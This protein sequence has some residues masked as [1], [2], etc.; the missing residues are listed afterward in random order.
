MNTE[1]FIAK[2][3][4]IH[5]NEFSYAQSRFINW[6]TPLTIEC[7]VH[8]EFS[9][10]PETHLKG[11]GCKRCKGIR[12]SI[13]KVLECAKSFVEKARKVHGDKYDYSKSSYLASDKKI[14]ITCKMHGDFSQVASAHLG[15]SGCRH[16]AGILNQANLIRG[17]EKPKVRKTSNIDTAKLTK[18]FIEKAIK[19]HG[20]R[21]DYKHVVYINN[22]TK[23][24]IICSIHD[25]FLQSPSLHLAGA[26]CKP[27]ADIGRGAEKN[28]KATLQFMNKAQAVHKSRYDYSKTKYINNS[29]KIEIICYKHGSFFIIPGSHL[30]GS[31]CDPCGIESMQKKQSTGKELFIVQAKAKHGDKFGYSLVEYVSTHKHVWIICKKHG[32]FR[33][34][35]SGHLSGRGCAQCR[36][37]YDFDGNE[38]RKQV[39]LEDFIRKAQ[40]I[41]GTKYNYSQAIY[42]K[43]NIV[44]IIICS[45]HGEFLQKPHKHLIGHGCPSCAN[46]D[47][48]TEKFILRAQAIHGNKYDYSKSD[49]KRG[50]SLITIICLQHGPFQQ[51]AWNHLD[52]R[53]CELCRDNL[54]SRG[55]LLIESWLINNNIPFIR[56][57]KFKTLKSKKK[58]SYFLRF[59]FFIEKSNIL[60]E[61]D[62]E[63]HYT[64]R[65][66]WGGQ[67]AF[68][69]LIS[70][71]QRKNIWAQEN[72]Y[73]LIRISFK[74]ISLISNIL[75][76][77]LLS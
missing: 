63:Q 42:E 55:I 46:R 54:N 73:R 38:K 19:V 36:R 13:P 41:H 62:G 33:Q 44:L 23:I 48:N 74:E 61:Y 29:L 45:F 11:A 69:E 8:G 56:E 51:R 67:K 14:I 76:S 60:I 68:H 30:G 24:S 20:G 7:L 66:H 12:A 37:K 49:Y 17:K 77:S 64:P 72:E 21:Y 35:P 34:A 4:K 31:G 6:K 50:R 28:R 32:A 9:Q 18:L 47:M 15:G 53:G 70:N 25:S 59:D 75:S 5:G 26:G 57:K 39:T 27:C 58:S 2:A 65:K 3:Q 22:H 10:W 40:N 1:S 16:C 71:D 52:G 43:S